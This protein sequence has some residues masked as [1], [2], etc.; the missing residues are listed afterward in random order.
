MSNKHML[1]H[2]SPSVNSDRGSSPFGEVETR[3]RQVPKL[4]EQMD[5][6]QKHVLNQVLNHQDA[7]SLPM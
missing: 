4:G 7:A 6:S 1:L 3:C 2:T 5:Y